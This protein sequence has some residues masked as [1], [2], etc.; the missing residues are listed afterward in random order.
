MDARFAAGMSALEKRMEEDKEASRQQYQRLFQEQLE[1]L[2][3]TGRRR[4]VD[5]ERDLEA[6]IRANREELENI[7]QRLQAEKER[8]LAAMEARWSSKLKQYVSVNDSKT[9]LR[10]FI[11]DRSRQEND[12]HCVVR[13]VVDLKNRVANP[14]FRN[15]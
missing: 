10:A 11:R 13:R 2:Q 8:D 15:S 5:K 1:A 6:G 4:E 9:V 14:P 12:R 7:R 3:E